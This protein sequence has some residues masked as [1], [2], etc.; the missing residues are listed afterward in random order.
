MME[1]QADR[2]RKAFHRVTITRRNLGLS[3][4][5]HSVV[6]TISELTGLPYSEVFEACID[7]E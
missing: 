6:I 5:Y 2:L 7:E 3:T 1:A 4:D